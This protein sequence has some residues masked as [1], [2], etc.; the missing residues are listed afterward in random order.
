MGRCLKAKKF[1]TFIVSALLFALIQNP[2]VATV[3]N[4]GTPPLD[5]ASAN[6]DYRDPSCTVQSIYG[7]FNFDTHKV[8]SGSVLS[9]HVTNRCNKHSG[10]DFSGPADLACPIVWDQ[11]KELGVPT[12]GCT[13]TDDFCSV[14]IPATAASTNYLVIGV[15]ITGDSGTGIA[16]DYVAIIGKAA[17]TPTPSPSLK[18]VIE[19][20]CKV[21]EVLV[22][23]AIAV[24]G[25]AYIT[26]G[27]GKKERAKPGVILRIGDSITTVGDSQMAIEFA[28]G[29]KIGINSGSTI[30]ITGFRSAIDE[31]GNIL[32]IDAGYVWAKFNE[33]KKKPLIFRTR[34]TCLGIRG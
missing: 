28:V 9:G 22:A 19:R 33:K 7:T 18:P 25:I 17:P 10:G 4:L 13:P 16:K 27:N 6:K 14:K 3:I 24:D 8:N 15:G 23:E 1:F 32:Q 31:G 29:G 12:S 26:H 20:P 2:A 34:N 21:G 30:K 11:V 5:C